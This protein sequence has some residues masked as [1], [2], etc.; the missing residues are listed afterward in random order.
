MCWKCGVQGHIGDKCFQDVSAF[1]ASLVSPS[2]S[3]QPSW[4]HVVR[5]ARAGPQLPLPPPLPLLPPPSGKLCIP[6]TAGAILLAKSRLVK[7]GEGRFG[8]DDFGGVNPEFRD[9]YVREQL[10]KIAKDVNLS[11]DPVQQVEDAEDAN[12]VA[13]AD[14]LVAGEILAVTDQS[15]IDE[16]QVLVHPADAVYGEVGNGHDNVFVSETSE[17]VSMMVQFSEEMCEANIAVEKKDLS[18]KHKKVKLSEN[19][20]SGSSD[21]QHLSSPELPHKLPVRS[22]QEGD[23]SDE[24]SDEV[25]DGVHTNKFGVN[26]LMWFDL[27]IE[28]KSAMDPEEE[29]WGGRLE[30]GFNEK[31]FPKEIEDYFLLMEDECSTHSHNCGGRVKGV[32]FNMRDSVLKPPSYNP[33]NV[34]EVDLIEKHGDAHILDSG[35]REV[36]MEEWVA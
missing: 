30:F 29:D 14:F 1:A 22:M 15:P 20:A 3:N 8:V 24:G 21:T 12:D 23:I 16:S 36:D 31:S 25:R 33:R 9:E 35:W 32:V 2:M 19:V 18:V 10:D 4:A 7:V 17:N 5:G 34:V 6:I 27:S 11:V 26:F 13:A 28:G